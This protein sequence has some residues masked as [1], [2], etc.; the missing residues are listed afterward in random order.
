MKQRSEYIIPQGFSKLIQTKPIIIELLLNLIDFDA[1]CTNP[2]KDP[3]VLSLGLDCGFFCCFRL[4]GI[5]MLIKS[6]VEGL[7][8]MLFLVWN[9]GMTLQHKSKQKEMIEETVRCYE[10]KEEN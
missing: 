7:I 5:F 6:L 8:D 9:S 3:S 10:L 4:Q 1:N 2:L